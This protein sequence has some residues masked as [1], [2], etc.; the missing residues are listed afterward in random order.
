MTFPG[1]FYNFC[2]FL[3]EMPTFK[4]EFWMQQIWQKGSAKFTD[5]NTLLEKL[6][7]QVDK[8]IDKLYLSKSILNVCLKSISCQETCK[9]HLLTNNRNLRL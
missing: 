6:R 9:L 8:I 2:S 1:A 5:Q 3:V 7:D 4:V